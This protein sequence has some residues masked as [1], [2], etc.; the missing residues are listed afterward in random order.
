MAEKKEAVQEARKYIATEDCY[1]DGRYLKRGTLLVLE[2]PPDHACLKEYSG[3]LK[4]EPGKMYDPVREY[5]EGKR[6]AAAMPRLM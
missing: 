3:E 1:F 5:A 4:D 6:I 2:S